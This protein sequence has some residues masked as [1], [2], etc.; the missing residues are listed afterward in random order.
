MIDYIECA[1]ALSAGTTYL[2]IVGSAVREYLTR[3]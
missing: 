1:A 3:P 2:V